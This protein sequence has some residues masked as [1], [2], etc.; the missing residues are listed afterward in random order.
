MDRAALEDQITAL[1]Q[2]Q[3]KLSAQQ[4]DDGYI[5]KGLFILNHEYNH[6][7]LYDDYEIE[8][9]V[10]NEF[11]RL[12]PRIRE[13]SGKLPSDFGHWY[14]NGELCLGTR[15]EI[16]DFLDEHPSLAE[17]V[18]GLVVSY[19]YS[20]TYFKKYGKVPYGERSHGM[21]GIIESYSE[22]YGTEDINLLIKLLSYL[23]GIYEFRG[24]KSCPCGSGKNFRNCH[25]KQ[26]LR[27]MKSN[28]SAVYHADAIE[29]IDQY[30]KSAPKKR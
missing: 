28:R 6:I 24:H 16:A 4:I 7:P 19:F 8:I 12:F 9:Q 13:T 23:A 25:G 17:F 15:C 26:L 2:E 30:I 14:A 3:P 18:N 20:V 22:R 27:D 10:P 11:P 21:F 29:I 1:L 5:I